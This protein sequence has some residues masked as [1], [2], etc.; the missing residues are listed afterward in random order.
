MFQ[1]NI[2][3]NSVCKMVAILVRSFVAKSYSI[4]YGNSH[5]KNDAKEIINASDYGL[6]PAGTS[7]LH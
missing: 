1:Q 4:L 2:F 3:V 5:Q 7:A 6:T